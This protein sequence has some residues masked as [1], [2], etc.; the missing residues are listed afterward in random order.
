MKLSAI[1]AAAALV[2]GGMLGEQEKPLAKESV[3]PER[4]K[5]GRGVRQAAVDAAER[6][7]AA[8]GSPRAQIDAARQATGQ[9]L[10]YLPHQST[11]ERLRRQK[12]LARAA[13]QG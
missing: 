2:L 10:G 4:L 3:P 13:A 1:S 7:F 6:V 12:R 5:P 11:R 9:K 8:G